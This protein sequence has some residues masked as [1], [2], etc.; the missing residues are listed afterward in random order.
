MR[1]TWTDARLHRR[2]ERGWT[3]RSFG[4]ERLQFGTQIHLGELVWTSRDL[5]GIDL[6]QLVAVAKI[7]VIP[8]VAD[9]VPK[10]SGQAGS[11]RRIEGRTRPTLNRQCLRTR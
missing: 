1:S 5:I 3:T 8:V 7:S 6:V 11:A 9:T 4:H 2:L 10:N